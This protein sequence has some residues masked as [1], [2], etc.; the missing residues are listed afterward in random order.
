MNV[1][2][3]VEVLVDLVN[4]YEKSADVISDDDGVFLPDSSWIALQVDIPESGRYRVHLSASSD[5]SAAFW[6]EDYINNLDERTYNITGHVPIVNGHGMIDG[7][8][9]Q[10]GTHELKLYATGGDLQPSQLRLELMQPYFG[11]GDTLIQQMEGEAWELVW[12]DEFDG[13]GLPDSTKWNYNVGNWGWGNHELQYYTNADLRNAKVDS[14][15]LTIRAYQDSIGNWH[16]ARLTTQGK[17]SFIY[18]KIEI[19]AKVPTV[20]GTW[21]AGWTL[22]NAYRDEVSWPYCGEIDILECVGYEIDD[23]TGNGWNHATCHTPAYYF[24]KNNQ[25]GSQIEVASMDT[26]YHIYAVE[27][28]P[29]RIE[30]YLDGEHYYTYDKIAN[31]LEWPFHQPQD[32]ILNLAIGGG[33]GG[34]KGIDPDIKSPKYVI[35]YVRVYERN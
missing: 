8:P 33:W 13:E 31:E 21:A 7:S 3:T 27:W 30:G 19:R 4:H 1:P 17:Q 34:L 28:Y 26:E 32:I 20:R 22:G 5:D 24:K 11:D 2:E 29:D 18:G 15:Y 10:A 9:L 14:G 6:L 12:G 35:D 25:I 16:S 23:S